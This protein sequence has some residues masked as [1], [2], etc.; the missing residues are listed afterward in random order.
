MVQIVDSV[1]KTIQLNATEKCFQSLQFFS[2]WN[3]E[4]TD[5]GILTVFE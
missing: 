2:K 4:R 3:L 5:N 1:N